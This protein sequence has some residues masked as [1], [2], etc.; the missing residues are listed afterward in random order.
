M[1]IDANIFIMASLGRDKQSQKCRD[2][3][4]RVESGEQKSVTSVL[5]MAEAL[6]IIGS[7]IGHEKA[8]PNVRRMM[9]IQNLLIENVLT[10]TL[11]NSFE[12]FGLGMQPMDSLH[13][14][15]MKKH[16]ISTILSYDKDFD[17]IKGIKRVEP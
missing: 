17:S 12:F 3:L 8:L 2:F 9:Q 15:V 1:F 11:E 13:L 10:Q 5:V 16:G 6:K 4:A 7:R 14:A